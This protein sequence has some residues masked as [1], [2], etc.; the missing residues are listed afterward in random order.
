M[1]GGVEGRPDLPSPA[2]DQATALTQF[3]AKPGRE[4]AVR[5]VLLNLVEPS[6]AEAGNVS[7]DVHELK[8][9][10][11]AF[12]ILSNWK[13]QA[14]LDKH[15]AGGHIRMLLDQ[16]APDL[17][18]SPTEKRARMLSSP[19]ANPDRARPSARSSTQVTLVPFFSIKPGQ[20]DA[21]GQAHLRMVDRTRAEPGCLDY[22]LYQ[23]VD[24]PSM[25]F[26]Y[27]NWTDEAA[28]DQHM[29]TPAFHQVVR[30]EIDPLLA[31]PWTALSM[32]MQSEPK[33]GP[34]PG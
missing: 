14:S 16:A 23:S 9:M 19:D 26:F 28:L 27:E 2:P 13:T 31:V 34:G 25:M 21:V 8:N 10:P 18:A 32:S 5:D 20:V 17:V 7:F 4:A 24:N 22:D 3:V 11:W 29:N 12:Y 1:P 6:R 15:V 30:G 33:R